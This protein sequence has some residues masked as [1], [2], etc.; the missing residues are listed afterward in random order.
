[1]IRDKI[2]TF[3]K[4]GFNLIKSFET[5]KL[6][7][8]KEKGDRWTIGWGNTFY[9]DGSPVKEGDVITQ[10]RADL[11]FMRILNKFIKEVDSL[12]TNP[13]VNNFMFSA[14]VSFAYNV[15]SDIDADTK[16]E[17]L[18]DSHLLK[19]V[20]LNPFDQHIFKYALGQDHIAATASCE[21]LGWVS[22]GTQFETGLRRRRQ[23]EA[24]LYCFGLVASK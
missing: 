11:L 20:N 2:L 14:L 5:C 6:K 1:M 8:Y 18:G 16:P 23:A 19:L 10:D 24:D 12:I 7:A 13:N 22:K 21:F 9:E 3:Q 17:G 4:A 15:G